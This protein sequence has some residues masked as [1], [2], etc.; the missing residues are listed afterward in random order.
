MR[1]RKLSSDRAF[2]TLLLIIVTTFLLLVLYP[3]IYIVSCSFSSGTA[4]TTGRVLLWPV[5]FSL[6]GYEIV[7]SHKAVWTGY[8]NTIFYTVV[9]TILNLFLTILVAYPLAR[10]NFQGKK[11]FDIYFMIPMF[12]GGGLIPTYI[13]MSNL[14]LTDNRWVLIVSGA[15][16]IYNMVLMRTYFQNSIPLELL[17]SAKMDGISDAGYLLKVVLPLAKAII[18]VITLYYVVAHWNS[19]FTGMIYLRNRDLFPLQLVLREI[20]N[21]S[22]IDSTMIQDAAVLAKLSGAA[23]VMKF[24]LIIVATVPMLVIYPFIQKFF[25]KGIMVGSGKGEGKGYE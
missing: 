5:D 6:V 15:L 19:Y 4:V 22:K 13:L 16:N 11:F 21:A 8:A 25:E 23:D 3:L 20:L 2:N 24:A 18:S 14:G 17:E 9:G 7:F 1:K 12:F 10:R